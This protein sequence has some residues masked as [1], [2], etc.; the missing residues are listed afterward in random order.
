VKKG[1]LK[2]SA[3]RLA[4][5]IAL[6]EH[7]KVTHTGDPALQDTTM[8]PLRETQ[9]CCADAYKAGVEK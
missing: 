1:S 9:A 4:G 2:E 8:K 7:V 6:I 5:T 3:D